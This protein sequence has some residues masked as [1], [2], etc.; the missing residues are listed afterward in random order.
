MLLCYEFIIF[1]AVVVVTGVDVKRAF[2]A[3]GEDITWLFC[4]SFVG[5]IL[6]SYV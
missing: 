4:N 1:A 5:Y 3:E 2:S 6:V